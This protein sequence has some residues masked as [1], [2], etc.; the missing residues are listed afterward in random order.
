MTIVA[1]ID[2]SALGKVAVSTIAATA[3]FTL[4]VCTVIVTGTRA[5]ELTRAGRT[6]LGVTSK[7]LAVLA[8]LVLAGLR[9]S[10]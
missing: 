2:W 9:C 6:G 7:V 5:A 10:A 8:L 1:A 4:S 3:L